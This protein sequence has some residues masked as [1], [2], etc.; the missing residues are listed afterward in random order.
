[1]EVQQAVEAPR[2]ASF[3]V[4]VTESPHP[5]W[6]GL[7]RLESRFPEAVFAGLTA[8]GHRVERWPDLAAL[9]GGICAIRRDPRT[10]VLAG[11]ADPR[12]MSYGIGW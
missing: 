9:A 11:G 4:P 2:W 3:A 1:M 6:P 12:R 7:V 8:R 5:S 10:G